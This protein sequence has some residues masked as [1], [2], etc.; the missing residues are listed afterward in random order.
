MRTWYGNNSSDWDEKSMPKLVKKVNKGLVRIY[1]AGDLSGGMSNNY[2][3][4]P[5]WDVGC[6]LVAC[7]I[8]IIDENMIKQL[9]MFKNYSFQLKPQHLLSV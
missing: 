8:H 9:E 2:N 7:N 6:Q 4:S 5:F 3:P 1:P